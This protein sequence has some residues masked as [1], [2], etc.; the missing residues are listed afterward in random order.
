MMV[1]STAFFPPV[2]YMCKVLSGHVLIEACENYP[3]QTFRNR[4]VIYGANGPLMLSVPVEKDERLKIPVR[5]VRIAEHENWQRSHLR[6]IESAYN[7]S[8]FYEFY[9]EDILP[10]IEAKFEYLFDYNQHILSSLLDL[11]GISAKIELTQNYSIQYS[12]NTDFRNSIHPAPRMQKQDRT[13]KASEY[14]QVFI[15]KHGFIP[16][17]SILD[18]LFNEGPNTLQILRASCFDL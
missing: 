16:N 15:E 5:E 6:S 18:L 2:Q 11:I 7:S 1:L 14:N 10:L 8:P 3:K 13:F 9:I 12:E 17:L 4:C